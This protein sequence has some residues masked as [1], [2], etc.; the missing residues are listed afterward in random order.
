MA[1]G[2]IVM[3][4]E[5]GFSARDDEAFEVWVVSMIRN[6]EGAAQRSEDSAALRRYQL[7]TAMMV[8]QRITMRIWEEGKAGRRLVP[9]LRRLNVAISGMRNGAVSH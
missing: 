3:Q 7:Q 1:G 8:R 6:A 9:L 4:L 2:G 5:P